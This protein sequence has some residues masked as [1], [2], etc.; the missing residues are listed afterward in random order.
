MTQSEHLN[1]GILAGRYVLKQELG[2]GGNGVVYAASDTWLAREVAI[3]VLKQLSPG[4]L[5]RL[6]RECKIMA[7]L[8]HDRV[9]RV[10]EWGQA[11]DGS[12]FIVME[13]LSGHTLEDEL[14]MSGD[15]LSAELVIEVAVQLC[16]ALQSIH[17]LDLVH[18]DIKPSNVMLHRAEDSL[19]VK[20][21]DFGIA[22]DGAD[23]VT[24]C[25][26]VVGTVAYISPEHLS[27]KLLDG[28]SD[29][30]SVGCLLY[31]CLKGQAPFES[32][33]SLL[34][35][36]KMQSGKYAELD[37]NV[38]KFLRSVVAR[39]LQTNPAERFQTADELALALTS[40]KCESKTLGC[41]SK[42]RSSQIAIC[43]LLLFGVLAISVSVIAL[44]QSQ[45]QDRIDAAV[46][47]KLVDAKQF[48]ELDRYLGP[49]LKHNI[50]AGLSD[51]WESLNMAAVYFQSVGDMERAKQY[52]DLTLKHCRVNYRPIVLVRQIEVRH[53][54]GQKSETD[55]ESLTQYE[56]S[57][58]ND[59]VALGQ[60]K[61]LRAHM[62]ET[63]GKPIDTV[64]QDYKDA[65]D[66]Y[67]SL[68][69]LLL[70]YHQLRLQMDY[71]HF[72]IGTNHPHCDEEFS[73]FVSRIETAAAECRYLAW[74]DLSTPLLFVRQNTQYVS[75]SEVKNLLA[76]LLQ[77]EP[78]DDRNKVLYF[79]DMH[80]LC[81]R[82]K[83]KDKKYIER[84]LQLADAADDLTK[85]DIYLLLVKS[86]AEKKAKWVEL[87]LRHA[88]PVHFPA[89]SMSAIYVNAAY[90]YWEHSQWELAAE[91][92]DKAIERMV[93]S[94]KLLNSRQDRHQCD[95]GI[96]NLITFRKMVSER[97]KRP[98]P[99]F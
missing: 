50:H 93:A 81:G 45:S 41:F 58:A 66:H 91:F 54:V 4:A 37:K 34:T 77:H 76:N 68:K 22:H 2:A 86:H 90:L 85:C 84:A 53:S 27:P 64:N 70:A 33:N 57:I 14:K 48:E 78:L 56:K 60:L 55:Y 17:A 11:E 7:R 62:S 74:N 30:F 52:N 89:D 5:K 44:Q 99:G 16:A 97:K 25:D 42:V 49:Y 29:I 73:K 35:L 3:K 79:C 71:L 12:P 36:Q 59:K 87:A 61:A 24:P 31:R 13:R 65:V 98:V 38:P 83:L 23:D 18:R 96:A 26:Q 39:C 40:R 46:A 10:F 75:D 28:R 67:D 43:V 19:E 51:S 69:E 80:R 1:I 88:D 21:M 94:K 20:L 63:L 32:E 9:V 82:L 8:Q 92:F 6:K 47:K 95:V 15:T 72:L